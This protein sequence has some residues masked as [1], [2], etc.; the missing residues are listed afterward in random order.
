MT[1]LEKIELALLRTAK[2]LEVLALPVHA[3][4]S[5][6]LRQ[7]ALELRDLSHTVTPADYAPGMTPSRIAKD[8]GV[9]L[10]QELENL[11]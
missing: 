8:E 5:S 10:Q 4:I 7:V 11:R 2:E 3:V 9:A 1:D 6:A